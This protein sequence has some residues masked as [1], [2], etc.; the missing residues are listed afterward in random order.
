MQAHHKGTPE[1][2]QE[3]GE[4]TTEG[5]V[6]ATAAVELDQVSRKPSARI[7]SPAQLTTGNDS[8]LTRTSL[9]RATATEP[10]AVVAIVVAMGAAAASGCSP[11]QQDMGVEK[12]AAVGARGSA[13]LTSSV[14]EERCKPGHSPAHR[15]RQLEPQRDPQPPTNLTPLQEPNEGRA[16]N[17]ARPSRFRPTVDDGTD[18]KGQD[19]TSTS[20]LS[21]ALVGAATVAGLE[22][23]SVTAAATDNVKQ[24]VEEVHGGRRAIS[25]VIPTSSTTNLGDRMAAATGVVANVKKGARKKPRGTFNVVTSAGKSF[26][27]PRAASVRMALRSRPEVVPPVALSAN[28]ADGPMI[29]GGA[30]RMNLMA[31]GGR[32][33]SESYLPRG[34]KTAEPETSLDAG[35][36]KEV[37][38]RVMQD[39]AHSGFEVNP[40]ATRI[41]M[42]SKGRPARRET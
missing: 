24:K 25:E 30:G 32:R 41:A 31:I 37:W 8:S 7:L 6:G 19:R 2:K 14:P 21:F 10:A 18:K 22:T 40:V 5:L 34:E 33:L 36:A 26:V 15:S 27:A 4:E 13:A 16:P 12:R 35:A 42:A 38:K 3:T 9:G 28:T 17:K 23:A 29:R 1:Q 20:N 11:L 39:N